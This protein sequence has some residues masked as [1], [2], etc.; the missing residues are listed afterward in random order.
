MF[1]HVSDKWLKATDEGR[2]TGAVF[3]DLAKAFDTVD[4]SILFTKLNYYGFR[5]EGHHLQLFVRTSA[6]SFVL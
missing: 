4:H 3:L 1:L 5:F 6:K 2:Y